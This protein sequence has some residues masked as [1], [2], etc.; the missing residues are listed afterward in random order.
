[1]TAEKPQDLHQLCAALVRAKQVEED[2]KSDR[3]ALE[4][5]I[6]ELVGGS[7][8]EG[9]IRY[10]AGE[11]EAVVVRKINHKLDERTWAEI[12]DRVPGGL[13]PVKLKMELDVK[14]YKAIELANP[15]LFALVSRAVTVTPA[16]TSVKIEYREGT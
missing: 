12:A 16:K 14:K 15:A 6:D 13:E 11:Y 10:Q 5:A 1:M 2:A 7:K 4:N 8:T 3:M 9:T